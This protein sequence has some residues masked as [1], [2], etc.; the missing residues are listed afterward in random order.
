MLSI[1]IRFV[2]LGT[3]PFVVVGVIVFLGY[4]QLMK[5]TI[6]QNRILVE[7][8]ELRIENRQPA[9]SEPLTRLANRRRLDLHAEMLAPAARRSGEPFSVRA[10][11]RRRAAGQGRQ[12]PVGYLA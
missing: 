9:L 2:L 6:G 11:R 7:N 8:T 5:L 1:V 10:Q 4:P 3:P 12:G